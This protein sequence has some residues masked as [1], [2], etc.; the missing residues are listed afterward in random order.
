VFYT[1]NRP[2][3]WATG[4]FVREAVEAG[5]LNFYLRAQVREAGRYVVTGRI[6][7]AKGQPFA[8]VSFNEEVAAGLREFKLNLFGKLL[9]DEKPAFPL[10]LRDV[11]A[12][13]LKPDVD[14]DRALMPRLPGKVLVSKS[15]PLSAFSE[16]EWNSEER[17][18]YL[19][20]Y[21]RDVESARAHL[22]H[23]RKTMGP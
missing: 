6:D 12:F 17:E 2:A 1:P 5:S 11:D 10:T 19:A 13:L 4:N 7:D 21:G 9:V 18:R 22:E 8:L 16:A 14:P 23:V 15:Y 20:E 3:I